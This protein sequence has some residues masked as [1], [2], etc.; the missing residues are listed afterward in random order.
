MPPCSRWKALKRDSRE[1]FWGTIA[2]MSAA[3]CVALD[4]CR[5]QSRDDPPAHA[6]PYRRRC[7]RDAG[8]PDLTPGPR[9]ASASGP[10]TWR[11]SSSSSAATL[12]GESARILLDYRNDLQ[13]PLRHLIRNRPQRL[14][15]QRNRDVSAATHRRPGNGPSTSATDR[16]ERRV[17]RESCGRYAASCVVA[18][19]LRGHSLTRSKWCPAFL[20]DG[21][22]HSEGGTSAR[23]RYR[24]NITARL[25]LILQVDIIPPESFD[26]ARPSAAWRKS[27]NAL[28]PV[29]SEPELR[30][31]GP[32]RVKSGGPNFVWRVH[33]SEQPDRLQD[34]GL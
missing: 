12:A 5:R 20:F 18:G 34:G 31:S 2:P 13:I 3:G 32:S 7:A 23:C 21:N 19:H 26:A 30:R 33:G 10:I 1:L 4:A 9:S 6:T 16:T 15:H 8:S 29:S 25:S 17:P 11:C 14:N 24:S 28:M 22:S 27:V